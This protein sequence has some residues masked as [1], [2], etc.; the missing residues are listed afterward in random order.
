[1]LPLRARQAADRGLQPR[2]RA[3]RRPSRSSVRP[4][5]A[6][7][8]SSTCSMRFYEID[9]RPDPAR[10]H[11]L[12][13]PDPRRGAPRLRH[14]AAGHLAVRRHDPGQHRATASRTR[15]TRRSSRRPRP[16]TSITS[17]V[18]CP[19]ATTP[20]L[21]EDASNISSGQKQLL[22]IAR[23]FLANPP[24]PHPRRGDEQRRHPHRGPHPGRDGAAAAGPD[25]LRHRPPAVDH[26]RRRHD[27]RHGRTGTSSSRATTPTC[28]R[29]RGVYYDA[30]QQPV[31]RGAR[32]II[33][34]RPRPG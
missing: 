16:P 11:R 5:R 25:Q 29:R 17:S 3:R 18:P 24:H 13:R 30:L 31:H 9:S 21:D 34:A 20:L 14:G 28:S 26:P 4:A 33:L 12:P 2:R 19:T 6:R 8:P 27:H 32:L 7:P 22:T 23:A 1:M 10:R 15:P